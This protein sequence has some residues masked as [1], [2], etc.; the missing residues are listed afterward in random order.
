M[1]LRDDAHPAHS[2]ALP[3][4]ASDGTVMRTAAVVEQHGFEVDW[5]LWERDSSKC[6]PCAQGTSCH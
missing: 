6:S 4:D 2:L 3:G 5:P 1:R